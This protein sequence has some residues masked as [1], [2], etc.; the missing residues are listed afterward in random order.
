MSNEQIVLLLNALWM[1]AVVAAYLAG[2]RAGHKQSEIEFQEEVQETAQAKVNRMMHDANRNHL[3]RED[4]TGPARIHRGKAG[5]KP[6]HR[7]KS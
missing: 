3:P 5:R 4:T 2:R 6:Q 7:K 1:L